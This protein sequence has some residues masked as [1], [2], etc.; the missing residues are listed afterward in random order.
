MANQDKITSRDPWANLRS[1]TRARIALGRAGASLP[2]NEVLRFAYA[3]AQAR[4]AVHVPLDTDDLCRSLNQVGFATL[5]VHSAAPNRSTYLLRPDL[6]RKLD[7]ASIAALEKFPDK[8]WDLIV[9]IGDGLSSVAVRKNAQP[10]LERLR[11]SFPSQWRFG[12]VVVANQARVALGDPVGELLQAKMVAVFIGER[13]GLSSPDSLGIYLTYAPRVGRQDSE[14][15]CISNVRPDG[16][17]YDDAARKTIWLVNEGMR[18]GLTGVNL[19]DRSDLAV[20]A[21]NGLPP[22]LASGI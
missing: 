6:G 22:A 20:F 19:K 9:V 12:P 4:D 3:H 17:G 14:R 2:T 21:S 10:V 16:L 18:L 8:G 15:N 13:P 1:L 11:T 7:S 5:P